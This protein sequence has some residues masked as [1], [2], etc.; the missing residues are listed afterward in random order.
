MPL[1]HSSPY[2]ALI[3]SMKTSSYLLLMGAALGLASC[4]AIKS[5]QKPL[6][7][8]SFDPLKGPGSQSSSTSSLAPTSGVSLPPGQWIETSMPNSTFF[9]EIPKGDATADKVLQSGSPLKYI[10]TKGSY[11]KVELNSGDVGYVPEIMVTDRLAMP[12]IPS[13]P[14]PLVPV[15]PSNIDDDGFAP[16][17]PGDGS[18]FDLP[19]PPPPAGAISDVPA[20]DPTLPEIPAVPAAPT[21]PELPA[22]PNVPAPPTVEGVTD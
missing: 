15:I 21:A 11:V 13:I 7:E 22:A 9:R 19:T 10:S 17:T 16:I 2:D 12:D 20:I 5:V 14:P 18:N 8:G 1:T 6:G 3:R 4:G